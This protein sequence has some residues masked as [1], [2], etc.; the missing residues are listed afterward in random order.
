MEKIV[1]KLDFV[2]IKEFE[3]DEEKDFYF[4]TKLERKVY[5]TVLSHIHRLQESTSY[6][7][8]VKVYHEVSPLWIGELQE[9]GEYFE[10]QWLNGRYNRW[11]VWQTPPGYTVSNSTI[12]AFNKQ[13]KQTWTKYEKKTILAS[14]NSLHDVIQF[15]SILK[16]PYVT[17]PEPDN[18]M[19]KMAK[20]MNKDNFVPYDL[21]NFAYSNSEQNSLYY[22]NSYYLTCTC[23]DYLDRK[24]CRHLVGCSILFKFKLYN[25]AH[26]KE[27]VKKSKRGRPSK[28]KGALKKD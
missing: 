14:V 21:Y 15:Y 26:A 16:R 12:E 18:N 3:S 13:I 9:F 10:K 8:F 1:E 11:Q 28:A 2:L 24:I 27:F 19:I 23:G 25:Y 6:E 22:V 4:G 7:Q 5:D 20:K 17:I